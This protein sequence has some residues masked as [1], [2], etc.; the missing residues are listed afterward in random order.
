MNIVWNWISFCRS[1]GEVYHVIILDVVLSSLDGNAGDKQ[2]REIKNA[3]VMAK[4]A[5]HAWLYFS[6]LPSFPQPISI[7]SEA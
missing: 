5:L 1:K 2:L 3:F 4:K 6:I 7:R